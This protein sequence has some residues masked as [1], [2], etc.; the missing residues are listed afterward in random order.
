MYSI[1]RIMIYSNCSFINPL[2]VS[3]M[4]FFLPESLLVS[5]MLFLFRDKGSYVNVTF[6]S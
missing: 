2:L 5:C 1:L 4:L 3:C 6:I